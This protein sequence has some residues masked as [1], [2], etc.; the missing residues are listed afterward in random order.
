M[1]TKPDRQRL[2]RKDLRGPDEFV[3]ATSQAT[4]WANEHRGLLVAATVVLLVVAGAAIGWTRWK[5]SQVEAAS[6]DFRAARATFEEGKL[7]EA[8]PQFAALAEA[9][10]GTAFGR[11]AILYRGHALVRHGDAPGG[12]AAYEDFLAS[13]PPA[14]YLKQEALVALGHA[15]EKT[16]D[17]AGALTVYTDAA[18]IDGPSRT[19]AR[20]GA[21]RLEEAAGRPEKAQELYAA[22]APDV[23]DPQLKDFVASKLPAEKLPGGAAT[24]PDAAAVD[25]GPDTVE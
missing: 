17:T 14:E 11:L 23:T 8:A 19:E 21:A 25:A 2:R 10:P 18:A 3:T 13:G 24:V 5:A 4:L 1:S 22:A 15:R 20:L 7:A 9:Y 16:G 6:R 12:V